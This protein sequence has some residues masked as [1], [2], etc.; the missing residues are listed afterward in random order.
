MPVSGDRWRSF[1]FVDEESRIQTMMNFDGSHH[2]T[3]MFARTVRHSQNATFVGFY[4][5]SG[6]YDVRHVSY[7][8]LSTAESWAFQEK[9]KK[10]KDGAVIKNMLNFDEFYIIQGGRNL[11]AQQ[12]KFDAAQDMKKGQLAR[13]F[14]SSQNKRGAS[15]AIL[16]KFIEKIAA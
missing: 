11:Q 10:K 1:I 14:I 5:V 15:R 13:A 7:R 16:G 4:I 12:A 3:A 6:P 8:Y 2:I 9:W